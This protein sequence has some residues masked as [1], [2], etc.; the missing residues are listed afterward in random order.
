[1]SDA[2]SF[3]SRPVFP[4][5]TSF[6]APYI[7][8][9]FRGLQQGAQ[10]LHGVNA[11]LLSNLGALVASATAPPRCDVVESQ[12]EHAPEFVLMPIS[13]QVARL[14]KMFGVKANPN[15]SALITDL[16]P[17]AAV[18]P[19][20]ALPFVSWA[21]FPLPEAI[22]PSALPGR[23]YWQAAR[24]LAEKF[25]TRYWRSLKSGYVVPGDGMHAFRAL[26][27][28]QRSSIVVLPVQM[29]MRFRGCSSDHARAHFASGEFGL[30]ISGILATARI[31]RDAFAEGALGYRILGDGYSPTGD[32][33]PTQSP[34]LWWNDGEVCFSAVPDKSAMKH[35]G[36]PTGF[37][38]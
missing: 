28:K 25:G 24:G 32:G 16:P 38:W 30:P 15:L 3:F 6:W 2:S 29:G 27:E 20:G 1:M 37:L 12:L 11:M 22:D 33:V 7:D 10:P 34:V 9:G 17:L 26:S 35:L 23:C 36:A 4:W 19:E 14:E 18:V 31:H 5:L 21:A 13:E 8:V